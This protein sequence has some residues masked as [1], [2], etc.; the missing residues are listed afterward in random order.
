MKTKAA[1]W[2]LDEPQLRSA[3]AELVEHGDC[4]QPGAD[5]DKWSP[6]HRAVNPRYLPAPE[7]KKACGECPVRGTCLMVALTAGEEETSTIY[8]GMW[9]WQITK[10]RRAIA[11]AEEVLPSL[12]AAQRAALNDLYQER[13]DADPATTGHKVFVETLF[14]ERFQPVDEDDETDLEDERHGRSAA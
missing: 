8:G 2:L 9:G 13:Y 12:H 6:P 4:A 1:A 5:P 14:D 3:R 10:L 11:H 7:A